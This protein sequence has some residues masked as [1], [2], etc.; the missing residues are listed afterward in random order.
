MN[1]SYIPFRTG[2]VNPM[3]CYK[4]GWDLIKERYWLFLG[5]TFV[6]SLI[7]S[8]APLMILFGPMMC[9]MYMCMLSKY[10]GGILS[11]E[12]LFKGFDHF[13]ESL[14]A[15]LI[16]IVCAT[17]ILIPVIMLTTILLIMISVTG[18]A[19]GE[20]HIA[21]PG[22]LFFLLLIFMMG[23][24][25]FL[26]L[27]INILFTFSY[28][29]IADRGMTGVDA[30]KTSVKAARGNLWGLFILALLTM[31]LNLAGI[32]CCCIGMYLILPVNIAATTVAYLKVF[33]DEAQTPAQQSRPEGITPSGM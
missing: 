9:G 14:I 8:I 19:Q 1:T 13:K 10:R 21:N 18:A 11:F 15:T 17:A 7:G 5:I 33:G 31:A 26:S 4:I 25:F 28:Q 27:L 2:A 24:M 29:L 32:L 16:L 30:V 6:G 12:I 22:P 3:D 23:V 20:A